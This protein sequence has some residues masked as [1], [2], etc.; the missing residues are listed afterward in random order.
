MLWDSYSHSSNN[1]EILFPFPL[2]GILNPI[3]L[4]YW[5]FSPTLGNGGIFDF[6][7]KKIPWI[8]CRILIGREN[9]TEKP[10]DFLIKGNIPGKPQGL[11]VSSFVYIITKENPIIFA[12]ECHSNVRKRRGQTPELNVALFTMFI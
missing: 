12:I 9:P 8:F 11:Q 4:I 7:E 3:V 5:K 1:V 2:F 10:W 6:M